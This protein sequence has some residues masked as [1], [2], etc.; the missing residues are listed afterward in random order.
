MAGLRSM[1][2]TVLALLFGSTWGAT[3]FRRADVHGISRAQCI[4]RRGLEHEHFLSNIFEPI[5]REVSHLT[6]C[7]YFCALLKDRLSLYFHVASH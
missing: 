2:A 4:L 6:L 1:Y 7:L 5:I 3:T